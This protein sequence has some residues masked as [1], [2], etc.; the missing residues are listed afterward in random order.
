MGIG[1]SKNESTFNIINE[2]LSENINQQ[3]VKIS[4]RSVSNVNA[5]QL[6]KIIVKAGRDANISN[7]KQKMVVNID[8]KKFIDN[9]DETTL[10]SIMTTS[11]DA[12]AKDN[13]TVDHQLILGA[14]L[15]SNASKSNVANS[16]VN[17]IMNSYTHEQFIEDVQNIIGSQTIELPVSADRDVNISDI[18]QYVQVELL[19]SQI[20]KA[21]AKTIM[22]VST[23]SSTTAKKETSQ[24]AS[25]GLSMGMITT[26]IIVIVV[27]LL[28]G[29]IIWWFNGGREIVVQQLE[30]SGGGDSHLR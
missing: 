3:L 22:D 24:S 25:G 8:I 23:E 17:R 12:A 11:L 21:M 5:T 15:S 9:V 27:A 6:I 16:A 4:Q 18:S 7:V 20:S 28:G 10:K 26:I 14:S 19:A 1:A 13:Q 2:T 30:K 29:A